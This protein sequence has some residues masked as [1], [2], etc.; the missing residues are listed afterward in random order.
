[1]YVRMLCKD[2]LYILII[3]AKACL[4]SGTK[5]FC[6]KLKEVDDLNQQNLQ[7][8]CQILILK[9][10]AAAGASEQEQSFTTGVRTP[11]LGSSSGEH[12]KVLLRL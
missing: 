8:E 3:G 11:R 9:E 5:D 1:M 7:L 12:E 4:V 2:V 10:A 6:S